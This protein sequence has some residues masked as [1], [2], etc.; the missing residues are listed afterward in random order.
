MGPLQYDLA[1]IHFFD[2]IVT[3][4][5]VIKDCK[6]SWQFTQFPDSPNT[7]RTLS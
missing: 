5:D 3:I 4:H 7:Y 2:Y 1:W 6:T